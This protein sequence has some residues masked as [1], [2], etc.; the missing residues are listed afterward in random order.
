MKLVYRGLFILLIFLAS[1]FIGTSQLDISYK[2]V[3]NQGMVYSVNN[4]S[5]DIINSKNESSVS[6]LVV[7][8]NISQVQKN[9]SQSGFS[10]N[11]CANLATKYYQ[12]FYNYIY[13]KS[14]LSNKNQI[15]RI[16]L[17]SEIF[18]NAP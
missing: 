17:L 3:K 18:P 6:N 4:Y 14:Y 12:K 7:N 1:I 13:S 5:I 10:S 11:E 2:P 15:N 9:N 16:A 8:S